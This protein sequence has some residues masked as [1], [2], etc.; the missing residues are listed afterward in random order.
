[1]GHFFLPPA[2]IT[3][4]RALVPKEGRVPAGEGRGCKQGVGLLRKL[5]TKHNKETARPGPFP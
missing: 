4:L 3:L 2:P 5:S 1:M